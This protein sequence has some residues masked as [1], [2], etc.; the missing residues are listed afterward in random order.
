MVEQWQRYAPNMT[1]DNIAGIRIIL[2]RDVLATHPDMGEG[3]YS[4]GSTIASQMGRFRPIPELSGYRT[5]LPNLYTCS[6]SMHSG[7]GIGR[8]SSLNCWRV[9]AQ[10]LAIDP[11][12]V[13]RAPDSGT[14]A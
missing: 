14:A 8:G 9:I 6:S 13:L 12:A 2:P 4:Q 3:G 1:D 7:S 5:L 10:D 11:E